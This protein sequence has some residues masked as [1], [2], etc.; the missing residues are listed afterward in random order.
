[1]TNL[2]TI[3]DVLRFIEE[4]Q[5]YEIQQ[6]VNG[7]HKKPFRWFNQPTII[8]KLIQQEDTQSAWDPDASNSS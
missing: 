7:R 6:K 2:P 1:M 5:L 3:K 4:Q 8:Q